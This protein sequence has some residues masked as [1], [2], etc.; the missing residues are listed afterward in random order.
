MK[1]LSCF[2]V[3]ILI[4]QINAFELHQN[5]ISISEQS[6]SLFLLLLILFACKGMNKNLNRCLRYVLLIFLDK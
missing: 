2:I 6:V 4:L 3:N 1:I 5:Y